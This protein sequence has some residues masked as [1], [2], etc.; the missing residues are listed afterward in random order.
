MGNV[1]KNLADIVPE[2]SYENVD[3]KIYKF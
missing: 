1:N 3:T 2:K